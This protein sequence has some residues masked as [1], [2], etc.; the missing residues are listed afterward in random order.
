MGVTE[1][2]CLEPD[3]TLWRDLRPIL[4]SMGPESAL[5]D[6]PICLLSDMRYWIHYIR[7]GD[8]AP[9]VAAQFHNLLLGCKFKDPN[10]CI[11]N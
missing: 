1:T 9:L 5:E 8:T 4:S 3:P 2:P 7:I 10:V 11:R 6:F